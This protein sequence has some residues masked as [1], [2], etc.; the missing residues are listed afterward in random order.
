MQSR[1]WDTVLDAQNDLVQTHC[2]PKAIQEDPTTWNAMKGWIREEG[3][4]HQDGSPPQGPF[5]S[6]GA[7]HE[8]G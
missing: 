5:G 2:S 1:T 7:S 3:G 8:P 6:T 4:K